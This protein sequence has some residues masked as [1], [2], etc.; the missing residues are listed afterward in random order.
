MLPATLA[1]EVKHQLLH[2]LEATFPMR[3][4]ANEHALERFF[5]DPVNGLF[6]GPW[7]QLRK[8]FRQASSSGEQ[9]F[10]LTIPFTPFKHQWQS[11]H[12]LTSKDNHPKPTIVTTGTGSGKTECFLYPIL[13]HCLRQHNEGKKDGIKAIILYPMNALAADQAGRFAEE[14]L[15]SKQL[16][17][18]HTING[19]T[20][21]KARIRVGLYTGRMQPGQDDKSGEEPGTYTEVQIIPNTTTGGKPAY[22]SITNRQAMQADPP[23]IL[24]T[25]YK[26]LDYLLMRPKDQSIWR[27]N[28]DDATL[29]RYLVL[30]ELHTYDG[31]QGA[32]VACLI[33]RLKERL[34][35]EKGQLCV[36]G[37]SAT[38]A[39][40]EDEG[41]TD[42]IDRLCD[43]AKS[44]FE[45]DFQ[46]DAVITEDRY[47]V[48]EIVRPI[49]NASAL[50]PS[51]NCEPDEKE[52][53]EGFA[54]RMAPLFGGPAYPVMEDD[55]WLAK[56]NGGNIC[57]ATTQWGL[58]LGEWSRTQ[59]IFNL[60]LKATDAGAVEWNDLIRQ[61]SRDDFSF[62][63]VGDISERA[64]VLMA[65]LAL[66]AQSRELRSGR[67]FPL[68][69]TQVQLWLREL[70]RISM[71]VTPDPVF[72]W[73]DEPLV[74]KRQLPAMH[75]TECGEAAWVAL[76]DPDRTAEIQQHVGGFGLEDNPQKIYQGWGFEH[77][78]SDRLITISPWSEGD[79]PLP[80][81]GQ[82]TLSMVR[83]YLAPTT[84]VLRVGQGPCPLSGEATFPVKIIYESK[85]NQN[86]GQRVG[87]R[88][89]PHCQNEDSLMFIG[90][91]AATIA[92]V[93]IDEVF[94]STLNNDPKLLAFTDS[95]QDASHRAG[96]FSA[97]TYNFTFRTALKHIID[98]A[99]PSGLP[100]NEVG[101]QLLTYWSEEKPGRP[102][103]LRE[104]MSTLIPPDLREYSE[105]LDFRNNQTLTSPPV[106]L[107]NDFVER[108]NWQA[109]SEFSLMM[110]HGR[111]M[112]LH[113]S[114]TLGW[115]QE[116]V[117]ATLAKL[118][119]RLPGLSPSLVSIDDKRYELWI[120]GILQRSRARGALYHPYFES[121][122]RQ[123][124]W[125]KFPFGRVVA[126]R[127]TY[128]AA[129]KYKP[130]L[131]VSDRDRFHDFVL[132]P[133]S[134]GQMVPWQII[135]ARRVLG[136]SAVDDSTLIDLIKTL[137]DV[138]VEAGLLL[139]L[140]TDGSKSF[141]AL[142][143]AA[144]RLYS[145][146]KKIACTSSGTYLYRPES[147]SC[148][149][150]DGP[151]LGYRDELGTYQSAP[152]NEREKYYRDRYRKGALRRVFAFE[153]TG[154]LTT[155][156]REAL[157][158]SFNSGGHADDPNVLT[159]TSTL[160]MGIDIGDLSTTMLCSIPPTVASYLQRIGRAGRSTGTALVMAVINQRPHDLFFFARPHELLNGSVEPPGCWLDANAVLVRQYLAYCFDSAVKHKVLVDIPATGKQL[161]DEV[162]INHAGHIPGLI[163][164][165]TSHEAELQQDFLA[166]FKLDVKDDTVERFFE[167]TRSEKLRERIEQAAAEFNSQ[168]Q[169][170]KNAGNRLNEQ[171]KKI[172]ASTDPQALAEIEREQRILNARIRKLGEISAL[173]VL[174]EHGL[175]PN[176]AFPERGVRF[177]GTTY[178]Q[179]GTTQEDRMKSY[180]IVRSGSS[181][182]R[183][184]APGNHFYTHSHVFDVQQLE[185]GSK[186]HQ[187]IEE[188]AVCGQCG[189]MRT[190][191]DV[192]RPDAVP[193][194]PQCGYVGPEGQT[195]LG[196][197][198]ACLPFHRSQAVSYMEYYE[199]L[200]SDKGEERENE[201]YRLA[202]SFDHT[203]AQASG[204]VGDD[205]LPFGIEYRSAIYMREINA[206]YQDQISQVAFGVNIKVPEG[207]EVCS[208]CGMAVMP[209]KRRSDVPHRKS[210]PG[211]TR[212]AAMQQE[213]KTGDAYQWQQTWLYRELRS[214]AIRLLLPDVER[215]DLDTLEAS[216][217]LGMRIR[218]QGDPAHLMVRPQ[219]IPDHRNGVTRHYL[220]LMDAVPG[221]T[222]FLKA[223]FQETDEQNRAAEGMMDVMR[224][225]LN[226]LET[227]ECRRL[228]QT[229]NDTDG[230]YRCIRTYHMQ[231]RSTNISRERGIRLLQTLIAAGAKRTTREALDDI[232]TE[233]LFG[234]VLEK[235][236]VE[237]LKEW[238][239]GLHGQWQETLINGS[240]GFRFVLGNP[241][242]AWELELQPL[243]GSF[244]G[245]SI[246]C[247]PD[248][249]LRC[250]D[251]SV[252]PIAIFADGFEPHVHSGEADN[253]LKDDVQKRR[254]ILESG[255]YWVWNIS[256][257]D[258]GTDQDTS[259]ITFLHDYVVDR[260]LRP[261]SLS[262]ATTGMKIPNIAGLTG[263]AW[264]QLK[265]FIVS[266]YE[267]SWQALARHTAGFQL[268]LLAGAG[269]G[270]DVSALQGAFSQW[271]SGYNPPP[272][273]NG[274]KGD[275][276][277]ST[278]ISI[279]EDLLA[280]S[281]VNDALMANQFDQ[282]RIGLRLDDSYSERSNPTN[283]RG[284]WR[285]YM[286][287]F[288]FFQFANSFT[289]F[290]T[291]EALEDTA[292]VLEV[293]ATS[294]FTPG[295]EKVLS[296][297][298][299]SLAP[300]TK[301]LAATGSVIPLVEY[302]DDDLD[303][304]LFAEIAWPLAVPPVAVLTG[305]QSSFAGVWQNAGWVTI[306]DK[307]I[308]AKG[309]AQIAAMVPKAEA[310]GEI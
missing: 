184:L 17:Y 102:G 226:A 100:I 241:E 106:K 5:N 304:E 219:I 22:V 167:E 291:T 180:E 268:I 233:A 228:N 139:N 95:V 117:N 24:L 50:P 175:L 186:T 1:Q 254:A 54:R 257:D 129:G 114:A 142:N 20:V 194:C 206:G 282:L 199:S 96:F 38:I 58:A 245:V 90:S 294:T 240:R 277:W 174:I 159:A 70:R 131:I 274:S 11:W 302:Y 255:Q 261:H 35:L 288:N 271:M 81:D 143:S 28:S 98:D 86:N 203:V 61:I 200:S 310:K 44:L 147:E 30:D 166:R 286:S 303:D 222:G 66:V 223:L 29:L 195:D 181:A 242:R 225:A 40:G 25:N 150:V 118:R 191:T 301:I 12:R 71:I 300:L 126:G 190:V 201:L 270:S 198:R 82:Q 59:S 128:P 229:D 37:T 185:V 153:H 2:Y 162:I 6:K 292:P 88:K 16:S 283:Y 214:E 204:A 259:N 76:I 151:S 137:L 172:D 297:V 218:F 213:G 216:I 155:E 208:G 124:Y 8:P 256:W 45:E 236:F 122:A 7:V 125:G 94:G 296:S 115:D 33:R 221:G 74:E 182:I 285:R 144:A 3:N 127:E 68:V 31:A 295:W 168:R 140:H 110:T 232:K 123:N 108:L 43:F 227:C 246:G 136:A 146:G 239:E 26:M 164:W 32:D 51:E 224:L 279:T 63:A 263:N 309:L 107:R 101:E 41:T 252:K 165:M 112:E 290:S 231:H 275:W 39:S 269:I 202:V 250:D 157:E 120:Y 237:R 197:H 9:F 36:M 52:T 34:S 121:Y 42:P 119:N 287:L 78:P 177:S 160:E 99:G 27:F 248:F 113:A 273:A 262:L 278:K 189:H 91:R 145:T 79:D 65:F 132:T 210:C 103:S 73:L 217:Y 281:P 212:T 176:Y 267:T 183:E 179:Y 152:L 230:C 92:S 284:R 69:P 280:Y 205:D 84:L 289:V 196:Q 258:L 56:V 53:A 149:W 21:R 4:I 293:S 77:Q 308:Q 67:A 178:N 13:D 46:N 135:W 299:S 64:Q 75:C 193:A 253:R 47:S 171:K 105:Y 85:Q 266:P 276:S 104:V 247:Q 272:L 249:M 111:T 192:T 14:I 154:L 156:E 215:E 133:S 116:V 80:D 49:N 62:R 48:A 188:W 134:P 161:V 209:G 23:D 93:A 130:H 307:D 55:P 305:D 10:D 87:V 238:V 158:M 265:S 298:V 306:T 109:V 97:R 19:K 235:K 173:E 251:A 243:L 72:H 163:S 169:L 18:D 60:L 187:L 170:L 57:D 83:Y 207:F 138:G 89:C 244:Q 15:K 260:I 264:Q 234:S 148:L 141:Y 211:R 220:V